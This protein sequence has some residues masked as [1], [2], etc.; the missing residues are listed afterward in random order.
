MRDEILR[1]LEQSSYRPLRLKELAA[2]LAVP[3][4]RYREFRQAMRALEQAGKIVRIAG[5][6]YARMRQLGTAV[7]RLRVHVR[8]FGMVA[9]SGRDAD[10]LIQPRNLGGAA[11]GCWVE[12]E[13]LSAGTTTEPPEG[14]VTS[15]RQTQGGRVREAAI[16]AEDPAADLATV[17]GTHQLR[18]DFPSPVLTEVRS[19]SSDLGPAMKGR[20][21]LRGLTV[22]T[23]DPAEARD[24]DDAVSVDVDDAG[25]DVLG[26]HVADVAHYV[27][28][29]S[30]VDGEARER[31]TSAYLLDRVIPM[32]PERLSSDLCTLSP[33]QDRLTL[34]VLLTVDPAGRVVDRQ[35]CESVVRSAARLTYEEVEASL[36][37]EADRS[38]PALPHAG[39]IETMWGLSQ[40]LKARRMDRGAIDF[41]LP[42]PLV[43]LDESGLP[44]SLGRQPRL[45]SHQ[46][47]EE[48]MLAAN[49][50]V[51]D[52]AESHHLPVLYRIHEA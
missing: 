28:T 23:I 33:G 21:D 36:G 46:L 48:F 19:L 38:G 8:G 27:G 20:R 49:E 13:L 47:I 1:H 15:V 35:V 12:V 18:L 39:V 3:P 50:S 17:A 2:D 51:A 16:S 11:D 43:G 7:G 6:R 29:G 41:D 24:F 45:R 37:G 52:L 9:R 26:V 22:L 32:L 40:R 31:G 10:I 5:S 30:A 25:R 44:V 42:E 4:G 34:S 14:R